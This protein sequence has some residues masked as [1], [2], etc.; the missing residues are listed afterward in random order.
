MPPIAH[1]NTIAFRQGQIDALARTL[2]ASPAL[3]SAEMRHCLAL[4]T[5]V[6][7]WSQYR[8]DR[9]IVTG[10]SVIGAECAAQR[11]AFLRSEAR[12]VGN[13]CVRTCNSRWSH[14]P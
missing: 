3:Y 5:L 10:A 7:A 9:A 6:R 8:E 4:R 13:E 12:R 2:L 1:M 14:Y 11:D